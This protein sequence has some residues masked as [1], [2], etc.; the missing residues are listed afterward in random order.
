MQAHTP[1]NDAPRQGP[2]AQDTGEQILPSMERHGYAPDTAAPL[3]ESLEPDQQTSIIDFE[4]LV[5]S[6]SGVQV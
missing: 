4:Q 1:D 3:H 6:E 2:G 5:S